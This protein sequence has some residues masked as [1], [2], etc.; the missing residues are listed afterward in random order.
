MSVLSSGN[1]FGNSGY[2]RIDDP[3]PSPDKDLKLNPGDSSIQT[4]KVASQVEI[5]E[6]T[7]VTSAT[8][9]NEIGK[10]F[11]DFRK[12]LDDYRSR[13][14]PSFSELIKTLE[15]LLTDQPHLLE[16]FQDMIQENPLDSDFTRIITEIEDKKGKVRD[17]VREFIR[18]DTADTAYL[19]EARIRIYICCSESG[20]DIPKKMSSC[21]QR[22]GSCWQI[23]RNGVHKLYE[24]PICFALRGCKSL[25]TDLLRC[26]RCSRT[27][28]CETLWL[29]TRFCCTQTPVTPQQA[30]AA[31]ILFLG[32]F[33]VISISNAISD[34]VEDEED[35]L[36]GPS[37]PINSTSPHNHLADRVYTWE[38]TAVLFASLALFSLLTLCYGWHHREMPLY[39][40]PLTNYRS[41]IRTEE[42]LSP[43]EYRGK[44]IKKVFNC[45]EVNVL[46]KGSQRS[47]PLLTGKSGVGKSEILKEI[48]RLIAFSEIIGEHKKCSKI[49]DVYRV[50]VAFL[51]SSTSDE[52]NIG[53]KIQHIERTLRDKEEKVVLMLDDVHSILSDPTK[54]TKNISEFLKYLLDVFPYIIATTT[55]KK[56]TQLIEK[57]ETLH[58][59]FHRMEIKPLKEGEIKANLKKIIDQSGTPYIEEEVHKYI[60]TRSEELTKRRKELTQPGI[61]N[62]LLNRML[63]SMKEPRY[64][65]HIPTLDGLTKE[66]NEIKA[67]I[68]RLEKT[69]CSCCSTPQPE[70]ATKRKAEANANRDLEKADGL[71]RLNLNTTKIKKLAWEYLKFYLDD[72]MKCCLKEYTNL[73]KKLIDR[74]VEKVYPS[75]DEIDQKKIRGSTGLVNNGH[76][77]FFNAFAQLI[78]NSSLKVFFLDEKSLET[79]SSLDSKD[80]FTFVETLAHQYLAYTERGIATKYS[81]DELRTI[82]GMP[83][84]AQQD[85]VEA[86]NRLCSFYNLTSVST[87]F[88]SKTR[89]D[90]QGTRTSL[91]AIPN[92]PTVVNDEGLVT[93]DEWH[94]MLP[95]Q[96]DKEARSMQEI[97]QK[98]FGE[99]E[100]NKELTYI[101]NNMP[102]QTTTFTRELTF[103]EEDL[104]ENLILQVIRFASEHLPS[105]GDSI[106]TKIED[107]LPGDL[108]EI[109][110]GTQ[111]YSLVGFIVHHGKLA[112]EGHYTAFINSAEGWIKWSDDSGKFFSDKKISKEVRPESSEGSSSNSSSGRN[113]T[114]ELIV[115]EIPTQP[116]PKIVEMAKQAYILHYQK[117]L[118]VPQFDVENKE[119]PTMP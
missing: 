73:L 110:I 22:A 31:I 82:L 58:S 102:Y 84:N 3:P 24:H 76:D 12:T 46:G 93:K 87:K 45:W 35:G 101:H 118:K 42:H 25:C 98:I 117:K 8:T 105:T 14:I 5:A 48:T 71:S 99:Q 23:T 49:T 103:V 51:T 65:S 92:D 18:C 1:L 104:K 52:M 78:L 91:P 4:S 80:A 85:C 60:F 55:K 32:L 19:R 109:R 75:K 59:R 72:K 63:I 106:V 62:E 119:S 97:I 100:E 34:I 30:V 108:F 61:A 114:N 41:R 29:G 70:E 88:T 26:L 11:D 115:D 39:I 10:F 66:I 57:N 53:E 2:Q 113:P 69:C 94:L 9:N 95:I 56:Y 64:S 86:F 44:I 37:Q 36:N 74:I 68:S 21:W 43:L 28:L 81:H 40:G 112:T 116:H 79:P 7:Q 20:D 33:G 89:V 107:L 67:K 90:L 17:F 54:A 16:K 47:H 15:L 77:C 111:K 38:I 27:G 96:I 83:G 50:T 6:L 13:K